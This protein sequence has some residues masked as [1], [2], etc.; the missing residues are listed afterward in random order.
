M[1]SELLRSKSMQRDSYNSGDWYN[2][3]DFTKQSN[4]WNVGLPRSDKDGSNYEIITQVIQGAGE[5]AQVDADN[6]ANMNDYFKE[7]VE[8]RASSGLFSLNKGD[9]IKRR[10]AFHN[11]GADQL[12]G[13]IVMSIDNSGDKFDATIDAQRQGI[14]VV[15]NARPTNLDFDGFDATDYQLHSI[16]VAKGAASL[17]HNA[18]VIDGKLQ[19][20]AWSSAVFEKHIN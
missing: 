14:V 10:L 7:L 3:V 2:R 11:T 9:E 12:A 8:L 13:V 16:S 5:R 19:V 4:N 6:I 17:A 15:I 20:P 18:Q 1:G